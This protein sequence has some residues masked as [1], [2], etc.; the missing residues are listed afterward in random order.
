[1]IRKE[2]SGYSV[3]SSDGSKRLSKP[4]SKKAAVKRLQQIEY[5]KRVKKSTMEKSMNPAMNYEDMMTTLEMIETALP[6]D[7]ERILKGIANSPV[8]DQL[9]EAI[10]MQQE[11][12]TSGADAPALSKSFREAFDKLGGK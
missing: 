6:G 1:M 9:R 7:R 11:L 10:K 12:K 4:S 3:F 5:F 2:G 8:G